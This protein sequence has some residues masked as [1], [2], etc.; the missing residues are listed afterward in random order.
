[1]AIIKC[2]ECGNKIS[3]RATVCPNCGYPVE[4]MIKKQNNKKK[5]TIIVSV[6]VLLILVIFYILHL[7]N[8]IEILDYSNKFLI[9]EDFDWKDDPTFN[10]FREESESKLLSYKEEKSFM[11][12]QGHLEYRCYETETDDL[13]ANEIFYIGWSPDIETH[14]TEIITQEK[15]DKIVKAYDKKYGDHSIEELTYEDG[16]KYIWDL[17]N[18]DLR[19]DITVYRDFTYFSLRWVKSNY[20]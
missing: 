6:F 15:V 3:S 17:P 5:K 2:L 7:Q 10:M 12:C 13:K 4:M 1:M 11:E 9:R 19:F 8:K 18:I 16:Q 14:S 20:S